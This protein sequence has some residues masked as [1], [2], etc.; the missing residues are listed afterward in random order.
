MSI[1]SP[2]QKSTKTLERV[3]AWVNR[4]RVK[5]GMKPLKKL[6]KG[7][8][9]DPTHCVIARAIKGRALIGTGIVGA[10]TVA[11]GGE[12]ITFPQYIGKFIVDFDTEKYPDLI[13]KG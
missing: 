12:Y 5:H 11:D 13:K 4:T 7:N 3:L 6:P 9:A 1:D 8:L 10:P 2:K